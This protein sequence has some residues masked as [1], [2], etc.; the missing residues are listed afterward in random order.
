MASERFT[1][2]SIDKY[3][4][5]RKGVI[6]S[7]LAISAMNYLAQ[8]WALMTL[9]ITYLLYTTMIESDFN[10]RMSTRRIEL[11][12]AIAEV[13]RWIV[14]TILIVDLSQT[15]WAALSICFIQLAL[16]ARG[17]STKKKH[18]RALTS[19]CIPLALVSLSMFTYFPKQGLG[20]LISIPLL[21][22]TLKPAKESGV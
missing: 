12:L 9:S 22:L 6:F 20:G 10:S 14:F 15:P 18:L 19:I 3:L 2:S 11:E 16:M 4:L 5:I 1:N 7:W 8:G 13:L 17:I 21:I